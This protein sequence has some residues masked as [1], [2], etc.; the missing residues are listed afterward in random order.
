MNEFIVEEH[1]QPKTK[2]IGMATLTG[3]HLEKLLKDLFM[4]QREK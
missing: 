4:I 3:F 2:N 1:P